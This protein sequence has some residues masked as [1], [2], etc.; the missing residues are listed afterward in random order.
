MPDG[1]YCWPPEDLSLVPEAWL[2]QV[3]VPC[4]WPR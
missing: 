2:T 1:G 4:T 3:K